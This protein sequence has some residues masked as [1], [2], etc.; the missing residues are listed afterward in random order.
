MAMC[1]VVYAEGGVLAHHAA[2]SCLV[3]STVLRARAARSEPGRGVHCGTRWGGTPATG[4]LAHRCSPLGDCSCEL[5]APVLRGCGLGES[6]LVILVGA[7]IR[8]HVALRAPAQ[9][10]AGWTHTTHT[11]QQPRRAAPGLIAR[12]VT[13]SQWPRRAAPGLIARPVTSL[14]VGQLAA[15]PTVR[16]TGLVTTCHLHH[17]TH[18][19]RGTSHCESASPVLQP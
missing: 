6:G 8:L 3:S 5:L 15:G 2:G 19:E 14:P 7:G 13:P 16:W 11:I 12:P 17:R 10:A 18:P 4:M 9:R 1:R